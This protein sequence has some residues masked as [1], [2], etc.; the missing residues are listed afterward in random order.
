MLIKSP[1]ELGDNNHAVDYNQGYYS[2]SA[3]ARAP[4]E[5]RED[6]VGDILRIT[7]RTLAIKSTDLALMLVL[8]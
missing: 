3:L 6:T 4:D 2:F 8:S 1:D 5:R 7:V